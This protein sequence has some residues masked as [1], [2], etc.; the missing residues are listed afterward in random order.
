MDMQIRH[1]TEADIPGID[2]CLLQVL[3]VHAEGRPD[4]FVTGTRKYTDVELS[5]IIAD[6]LRPVF[7]AV[8]EDAEPGVILGYAFC[9]V[10][11]F[12]GSNNMQPIRTLYVDDLCVDVDARR[13]TWDRAFTITCLAGP[14]RTAFTT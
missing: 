13:G 11:D 4:L 14:A 3:A 6:D 8:E 9:E 5:E 1:A 7:V 2:K 10:Q 12:S